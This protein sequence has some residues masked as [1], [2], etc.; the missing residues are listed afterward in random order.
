[1]CQTVNTASLSALLILVSF[2]PALA[3]SFGSDTLISLPKPSPTGNLSVEEA[4]QAR[5]SIRT[6]SKEPLLLSE[7]SQL[8][9]AGQGITRKDGKRTAPSA[10][11][12]YP[13][14]MYVVCGQVHGLDSGVYRYIPARHGLE[15]IISSG[16]QKE[17]AAVALQ[18]HSITD[19]AAVLVVAGVYKR[20]AKK[21]GGRAERYVH[22][23]TGHAA[24]NILLQAT[25]LRLNT[26]VIGAFDDDG[27][28]RVLRMKPNESPLLLLPLGRSW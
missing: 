18:Q 8:L 9:W 13:L 3:F 1:M 6:Y 20:T 26:V 14:E 2:F 4:L 15:Q 7:I 10:G 23:E 21:Y 16:R 22:I 5:K 19:A 17:L 27:V 11:A 12:L 24:Q 28:K 25:A